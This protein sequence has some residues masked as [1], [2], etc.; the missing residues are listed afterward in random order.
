MLPTEMRRAQ[1]AVVDRVPTNID[2]LQNSK[3]CC[4]KLYPRRIPLTLP[5]VSNT[6][7]PRS[8]ALAPQPLPPRPIQ[9]LNDGRGSAIIAA[10]WSVSTSSHQ[11]TVKRLHEWLP[12]F[13]PSHHSPAPRSRK[14]TYQRY[15]LHPHP[16][17][18]AEAH[19]RATSAQ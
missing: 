16:Y 19:R 18:N 10:H 9:T 3:F 17:H 7:N 5:R 6:S 4:F 1:H 11:S 13:S 14:V 8:R 15:N 2:Y 12:N